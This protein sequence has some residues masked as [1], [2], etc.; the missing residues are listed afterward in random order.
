ML[1]VF[2]YVVGALLIV[3]KIKANVLSLCVAGITAVPCLVKNRQ[4]A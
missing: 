3:V 1:V 4:C 2:V